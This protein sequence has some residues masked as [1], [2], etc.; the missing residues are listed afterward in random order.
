MAE[1]FSS[2][3]N[4]E[5]KLWVTLRVLVTK[6]GELSLEYFRG[7]RTRYFPP[8]KL[9]LTMS[10]L[11]FSLAT[12][13]L[14]L[15]APAREN[16]ASIDDAVART[17]DDEDLDSE[18][19]KKLTPLSKEFRGLARAINRVR[20]RARLEKRELTEAERAEIASLAHATRSAATTAASS[21]PVY[22]QPVAKEISKLALEEIEASSSEATK[23]VRSQEELRTLVEDM[24]RSSP[25]A[26]FFFLPMFAGVY[27][28]LF[29]KK[30]FYVESFIFTLHLHS[31]FL[32]LFLLGLFLPSA[33][34]TFLILLG[35]AA[36]TWKALQV[37]FRISRRRAA[38][39]ALF[40]AVCYLSLFAII[41]SLSEDASPF[42][43]V[44]AGKCS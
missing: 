7:R 14:Y 9:Y 41:G 17:I 2:Y 23:P 13:R 31:F 36:Y 18:D 19:E 33:P 16:P 26:L 10:V 29:R 32:S 43:C 20:E 44:V 3:F 5:Q 12:L 25:R 28:F 35:M 22:L 42:A 27:A 11:F 30:S 8:L 15:V 40:A 21:L 39:A 24:G 38:S 34:A 4:L 6:P 1:W 37:V